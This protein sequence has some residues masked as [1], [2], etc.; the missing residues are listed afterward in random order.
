MAPQPQ[1]P[2]SNM[3]LE[4]VWA[5]ALPTISGDTERRLAVAASARLLSE[6]TPVDGSHLLDLK[7]RA[8]K[9]DDVFGRCAAHSRRWDCGAPC[10]L[11]IGNHAHRSLNM[12]R[13]QSEA[14]KCLSLTSAS[15]LP[16]RCLCLATKPPGCQY[17]A[18]P[19]CSS[20]ANSSTL[21]LSENQN[22][23]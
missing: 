11:R 16:P 6:V 5:P 18:A 4:S 22:S 23:N 19:G 15:P 20:Y 3:I 13:I 7:S 9:H 12:V 1:P 10:T 14:R 17:P 8:A 2:L 21:V